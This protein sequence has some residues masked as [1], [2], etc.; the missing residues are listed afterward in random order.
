MFDLIQFILLHWNRYHCVSKSIK[1]FMSCLIKN[2]WIFS[3]QRQ[4]L[5]SF[6]YTHSLYKKNH[7]YDTDELIS[8]WRIANCLNLGHFVMMAVSWITVHNPFWDNVLR[9]AQ[10]KSIKSCWDN[11]LSINVYQTK[12]VFLNTSLTEIDMSNK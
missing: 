9:L 1:M 7:L 2:L 11:Q 5:Y 10:R 8:F 4:H 6:A 3:T 12:L